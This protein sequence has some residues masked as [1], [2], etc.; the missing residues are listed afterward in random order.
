MFTILIKTTINTANIIVFAVFIVVLNQPYVFWIFLRRIGV[1]YHL[2]KFYSAITTGD[3]VFIADQAY[4]SV[5][6]FLFSCAVIYECS[7]CIKIKNPD[8]SIIYQD[9]LSNLILQL[10]L[11]LRF[12]EKQF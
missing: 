2:S 4:D 11:L 5:S 3:D 9:F 8:K 7:F 1:V 10:L 6:F 12:L